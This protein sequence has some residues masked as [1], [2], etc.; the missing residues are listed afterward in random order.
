[1][2]RRNACCSFCKR[3]HT[4]VGPL[5]EGPDDVYICGECASLCQQIVDEEQRRRTLCHPSTRPEHICARLDKIVPG[6]AEAKLALALA[7]DSQNERGSRVLLLGPSSSAKLLLARALAHTLN[8]PF[9]AGDSIALLRS[10]QGLMND[11]PLLFDLLQSSGFDLEATQR[12]VVFVDG[13]ER[14]ETQDCLLRVWRSEVCRP[15]HGI[16]LAVKHILFVCGGS[17]GSLD[18]AIVCAGLHEEQPVTVNELRVVGVQPEFATC[19]TGIAR[20]TPLHEDSLARVVKWVDFSCCDSEPAEG[21]ADA[22][23]PRE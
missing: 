8:V 20:V 14:P 21:A 10:K 9:A 2:K 6:Q 23:Q 1:M 22:G 16:A 19:L 13:A 4:E 5:V 3:S 17:F 18:D 12:G 7:A 11:S 15:N